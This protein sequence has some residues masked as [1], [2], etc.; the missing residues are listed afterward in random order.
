MKKF[1]LCFFY[2]YLILLFLT[3]CTGTNPNVI[4]KNK[5]KSLNDGTKALILVQTTPIVSKGSLLYDR[6][7]RIETSWLNLY[8]PN[9]LIRTQNY[10][11]V[12]IT[13]TVITYKYQDIELYL[14]NPGDYTLRSLIYYENDAV[15]YRT[16][17]LNNFANFSVKG[18][19]ILYIGNL[20]LNI[21]DNN[22]E[23]RKFLRK[24]LTVEDNYSIAKAYLETNHPSLATKLQKRLIG[25]NKDI[26]R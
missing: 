1:I 25:L 21:R 15:S 14:V 24:A 6:Q 17:G 19:E 20:V 9:N 7:K 26:S 23:S 22:I 10:R 5:L 11:N 4:N 16:Q 13:P 12:Y 2:P 3:G 8:N 18:G